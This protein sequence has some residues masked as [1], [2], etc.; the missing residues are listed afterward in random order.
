MGANVVDVE[1]VVVVGA[2]VVDVEEVV[3]V[4]AS[5]VVVARTSTSSVNFISLFSELKVVVVVSGTTDLVTPVLVHGIF[6]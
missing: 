1:E 3:V 2:S 4:G 6:S 5:V